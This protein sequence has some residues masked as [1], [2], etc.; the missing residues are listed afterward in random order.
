MSKSVNRAELI[1]NLVKD[2]EF[3]VTPTGTP[4]ATFVVAT[5]RSWKTS[6]GELKEETEFHRV[7]AWQ[8]LAD[9]C[10]KLLKKGS[11]VYVEGRMASKKLDNGTYM[12]EVV[13]DDVIILDKAPMVEKPTEPVKAV[14]EE[15]KE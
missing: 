10:A 15:V 12:H 9:I 13:A 5:N 1:G 14:V 2:V 4:I 11:K 8:K 7:V 3:K 6:A